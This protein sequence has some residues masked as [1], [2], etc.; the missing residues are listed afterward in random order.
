MILL[1]YTLILSS[2]VITKAQFKEK[3]IS[4]ETKHALTG[5]LQIDII[6]NINLNDLFMEQDSI[7]NIQHNND[8]YSPLKAG[9]YS[10][11]LPGA[12]QFYTKSYWQSAAFLSVEVMSWILYVM[13]EN[14]GDRQTEDFQKYA[15]EHWSVVD[16]VKWIERYYSSE[17]S[18]FAFYKQ[19]TNTLPPWEQIDWEQLNAC[20]QRIGELKDSQGNMIKT[21][22]SHHLP[23]RPEQQYYELIGKYPQ[24]GGGWDDAGLFTFTKDDVLT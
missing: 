11:I 17:A 1:V 9:L 3:Y 6:S 7:G 15:D 12:G 4:L 5:N 24:Y 22:F 18:S 10:A 19:N 2:S 14:K 16:Y 21:G 8:L 20:E 13:N 23:Q